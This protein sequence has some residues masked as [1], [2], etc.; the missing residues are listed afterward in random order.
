MARRMSFSLTQQQ[1]V[2]GTKDV[3]RRLGWLDTREGDTIVALEKGMGL[4]KGERQVELGTIVVKRVSRE[5]LNTISADEV[6]REGF[7]A[8]TPEAFIEL[9]CRANKCAPAAFVTRIE[10]AF[11]RKG[12]DTPHG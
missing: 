3:T 12:T 8:L 10:F 9:F 4:R 7:P 2:D 11:T 6:R 5:R 1:L